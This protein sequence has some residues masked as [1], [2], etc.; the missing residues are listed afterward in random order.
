MGEEIVERGP[1]PSWS[2]RG[3]GHISLP[4]RQ[5]REE[6][7]KAIWSIVA[8]YLLLSQTKSAVIPLE[9]NGPYGYGLRFFEQ[10][11]AVLRSKGRCLLQEFHH[12]FFVEF[13]RSGGARRDGYTD[14]LEELIH[15]CGGTD[16]DQASS[17]G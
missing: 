10:L 11:C 17:L 14:F 1:Y 5:A 3:E 2:T 6:I 13:G 8:I 4:G 12:L 9:T 7:V 16:A 15:A